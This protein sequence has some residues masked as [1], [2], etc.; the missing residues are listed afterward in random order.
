MAAAA[1]PV[2][3]AAGRSVTVG[4][5]TEGARPVAGAAGRSAGIVWPVASTAGL[6]AGAA[7]RGVSAGPI[8]EDAEPLDGVADN[9]AKLS[10]TGHA[11]PLQ[12]HIIGFLPNRE[13][14]RKPLS[15]AASYA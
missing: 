13:W 1:G 7:G 14:Y 4:P 12:G 3:S 5:I 11:F 9:V 8:T 6:V 2:A 15:C 10:Q